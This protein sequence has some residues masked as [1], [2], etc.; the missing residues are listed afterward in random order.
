MP[1]E[2]DKGIG[3]VRSSRRQVSLPAFAMRTDGS[4][5]NVVL[6]DLSYDGSLIA[7]EEPFE[8]GERLRLIVRRRGIVD[9]HVCWAKD[10]KAG[11]RFAHQ[12]AA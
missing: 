3:Q 2:I 6:L 12:L 1:E 10:G 7:S 5:V 8:V 4:T 9:A 11:V